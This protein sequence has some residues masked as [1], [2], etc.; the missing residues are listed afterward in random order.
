VAR[1]VFKLLLGT[2]MRLQHTFQANTFFTNTAQ[3]DKLYQVGD[4]R[5]RCHVMLRVSMTKMMQCLTL[6]LLKLT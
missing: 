5:F 6:N 3:A 1:D 4:S 2:L